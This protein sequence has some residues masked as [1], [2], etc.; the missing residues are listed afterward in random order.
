M[1]DI[2]ENVNAYIDKIIFENDGE[3]FMKL[4]R[5]TLKDVVPFPSMIINVAS[6]DVADSEIIQRIA[7]NY[8]YVYLTTE[9]ANEEKIGV[10]ANIKQFAKVDV[11]SIIYDE[12]LKLIERKK[13]K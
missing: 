9:N 5:V 4:H 1:S 10:L 13:K 8:K 11:N 2:K 3:L 7:A 6:V 12:I